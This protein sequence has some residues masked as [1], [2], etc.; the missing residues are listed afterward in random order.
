MMSWYDN[1][2]NYDDLQ[3]EDVIKAT[4]AALDKSGT[5]PPAF[6]KL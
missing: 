1:M 5:N 3:S 4:T 2:C 6:A